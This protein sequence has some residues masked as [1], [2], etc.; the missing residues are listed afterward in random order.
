MGTS[1]A[2][3][4]VGEFGC[5]LPWLTL[6]VASPRSIAPV[7]GTTWPLLCNIFSV[8][9]QSPGGRRHDRWVRGALLFYQS[10]VDARRSGSRDMGG[11][12]TDRALE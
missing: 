10:I 12:G 8:R 2:S 1:L 9:K 3:L 6:T 11:Q 5:S 7:V 4:G